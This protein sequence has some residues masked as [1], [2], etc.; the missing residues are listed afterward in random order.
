MMT[1]LQS[2]I[3]K[4]AEE[5]F[6]RFGI[7]SLTMDDVARELGI[8]K[9]TLYQVVSSKDDLV[10]K[11]LELDLREDE[12]CFGEI[13]SSAADAIDEMLKI[14]EMVMLQLKH[15]KPGIVRELQKYHRENW[16]QFEKIHH[17][18]LLSSTR[19]NLGRG[20]RE[21]FFRDDFDL[22]RVAHIQVLT[23]MA[24]MN[25][26]FEIEKNLRMDDLVRENIRFYLHAVMNEKGRKRL[27]KLLA[28]KELNPLTINKL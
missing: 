20:R 3:F 17:D 8:S 23:T 16:L 24:L 4:C 12:A 28:Q 14:E 9:K 11:V 21:G 6:F 22:E 2:K 7:K 27:T 25:E 26:A 10:Q 5:L 13:L 15:Y 18:R 1:D 19:N